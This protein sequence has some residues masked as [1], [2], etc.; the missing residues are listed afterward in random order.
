M[1]IERKCDFKNITAEEIITYKFAATIKDKR[2]RDKFIKGPL[3]IQLVL[4]TIELDNYNRKN[5]D[6]KLRN[7]KDRKGSTSS[8]TSSELIGHTKQTRKRKPHFME[9][10]NFQFEIAASMENRTGH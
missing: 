4:E 7:K 1:D 2:A 10:K 3:K 8:S 9:K 5:I 6:K